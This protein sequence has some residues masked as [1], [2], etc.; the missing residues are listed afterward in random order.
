MNV[1]KF[2]EREKALENEYIRK[3]EADKFKPAP[4]P[5]ANQGAPKQ[6][7][8]SGQNAGNQK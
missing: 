8:N 2:N 5:G 7:G 4:Q 6:T 1:P 3:R